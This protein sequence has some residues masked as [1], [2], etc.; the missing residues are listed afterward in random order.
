[1]DIV[2]STHRMTPDQILCYHLHT[3]S[4][5]FKTIL[6]A[7]LNQREKPDIHFNVIIFVTQLFFYNLQITRFTCLV[8]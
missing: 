5:Y 2:P 1:M 7:A 8:P 4:Q 6:L 3:T